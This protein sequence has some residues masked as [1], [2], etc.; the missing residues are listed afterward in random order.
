MFFSFQLKHLIDVVIKRIGLDCGDRFKADSRKVKFHI[1]GPLPLDS[2]FPRFTDFEVAHHYLQQVF[3]INVH[4]GA[5][6][7][8]IPGPEICVP[9]T[10]RN[11]NMGFL[12]NIL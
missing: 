10:P 3:L 6:G 5:P 2:A 7:V 4:Y 11:K 1:N 9:L 8:P 12:G